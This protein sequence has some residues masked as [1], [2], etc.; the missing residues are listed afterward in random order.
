M[1]SLQLNKEFFPARLYGFQGPNE[2]PSHTTS[3]FSQNKLFIVVSGI[4][5]L[6]WSD[7]TQVR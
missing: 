5:F 7:G 6:S 1:Q 4:N 3:L 2:M